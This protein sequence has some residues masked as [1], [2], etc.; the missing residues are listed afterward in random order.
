MDVADKN[1]LENAERGLRN[2]M[3]C[4][5]IDSEEAITAVSAT[6][7]LPSIATMPREDRVAYYAIKSASEDARF[8]EIEPAYRAALSVAGGA[9]LHE[10]LGGKKSDENCNTISRCRQIE[11]AAILCK[12]IIL[13]QAVISAWQHHRSA[14]RY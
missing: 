1:E 9:W 11:N 4:A 12:D 8:G 5:Q 7:Q 3:N 2:L 13:R 10:R 14:V 6:T